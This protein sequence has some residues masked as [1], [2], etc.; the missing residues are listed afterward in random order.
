MALRGK[1]AYL[2]E[3]LNY[4]RSHDSSVRNK[5][6]KEALD[7]VE[8]LRVIRWILDRVTPTA[9]VL[10][11]VCKR[12]AGFWVPA[13]LST[14]VPFS[15]KLV[16]L[17]GVRA[18]DPHPIERALRTLFWM[19]RRELSRHWQSVRSILTVTGT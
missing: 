10:K 6:R 12:Q 19:V 15:S 13:L 17:K 8:Y 5:S 1:M 9:S 16:I 4:F 14:T 11:G 2:G 18:I 3:P 7:V